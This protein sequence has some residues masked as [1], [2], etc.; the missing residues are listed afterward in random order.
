LWSICL[1]G[2]EKRDSME[3]I[4]TREAR[5]CDAQRI[6]EMIAHL[7]QHHDDLAQIEGMRPVVP[8]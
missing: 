7:A 5:A 1:S 4:T 6:V 2:F 3:Q 8:L